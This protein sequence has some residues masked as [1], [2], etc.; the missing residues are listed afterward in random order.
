MKTL[1]IASRNTGKA[2]ELAELFV[3][4]PV[5]VIMGIDAGL[6]DVE[7]TGGSFR[8]NALLKAKEG[9]LF[10]GECSVADDC[11][12]EIASLN[13][14]PGIFSKRFA[15]QK[16]SWL[17]A[18]NYL[19]KEVDGKPRTAYMCCALAIAWPD[20]RTLVKVHRVEGTLVEPRGTLGF[21]FDPCFLPTGSLQT[22]GEM[23]PVLRDSIN[24]RAGAFQKLQPCVDWRELRAKPVVQNDR[25]EV[26]TT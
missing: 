4:H 18:M 5:R 11:G 23:T 13:N 15:L 2:K 25:P 14:R 16:G 6:P 12:L 8:E 19:N 9:A 21:G 24:H 17:E 26:F 7:E 10:S 3:F 22:Y 1:L 20:G